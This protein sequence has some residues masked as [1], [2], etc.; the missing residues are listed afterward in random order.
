MSLGA[1]ASAASEFGKA[2]AD[3]GKSA[4]EGV[5]EINQVSAVRQEFPSM[6]ERPD[7]A[8]AKP[9]GLE[10]AKEKSK[11]ESPSAS[12]TEKIDLPEKLDDAKLQTNA[13]NLKYP[14]T[15][16]IDGKKHYYDDNGSLYRVDNELRPNNNYEINGYKYET[17]DKGRITSVEGKLHLKDR[18]GRLPIR[19]SIEDIGKGDQR[20][21]D[22]RGH[23]IGDQFDG[24]NGLEN[25]IPQDA[26]VNRNDFRN[27]ENQLA[28]EVKSGKSVSV[29]IEPIYEGDSHRPSDIVVTYNIN[30]K[31]DVRIFPNSKEDV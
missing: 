17:D 1:F 4:L 19:D 14:K 9:S 30:G 8:G 13:E 16:I 10:G 6:F 26:E 28:E 5:K 24:S 25:M 7:T 2:V 11:L 15:E 22:D 3:V 29:K 12:R 21:G 31:E 23:L 20:E 18:E 27:F